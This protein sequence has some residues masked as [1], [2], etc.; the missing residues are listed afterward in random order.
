MAPTIPGSICRSFLPIAFKPLP[1]LLPK[2]ANPFF[3]LDIITPVMKPTAANTEN[4]VRPYFSKI[5]LILIYESHPPS[6]VFITLFQPVDCILFISNLVVNAWQL[7]FVSIFVF[8]IQLIDSYILSS[9]LSF[10]F[11]DNFSAVL[12]K[13]SLIVFGRSFLK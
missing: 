3:R 13:A 10:I 6:N 9:Y 1:K 8:S 11:S 5:I 12:P 4:A 7:I 2:V